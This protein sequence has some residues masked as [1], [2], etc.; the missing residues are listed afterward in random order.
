MA[1]WLSYRPGQQT[2]GCGGKKPGDRTRTQGSDEAS[3]E[4]KGIVRATIPISNIRSY[5]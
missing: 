5:L 1:Q 3:E 4:V 2:G